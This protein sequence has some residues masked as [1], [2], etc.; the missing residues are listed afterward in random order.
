MGLLLPGLEVLLFIC[1][2]YQVQIAVSGRPV[3]MV[4]IAHHL[5]FDVA[6]ALHVVRGS[7]DVRKSEEEGIL[8]EVKGLIGLEKLCC[9]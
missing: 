6:D 2:A 8:N 9:S 5:V 4:D 3:L 7:S 1:L